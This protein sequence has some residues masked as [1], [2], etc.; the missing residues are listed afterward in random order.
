MSDH[1]SRNPGRVAVILRRNALPVALLMLLALV[2]V[3]LDGGLTLSYRYLID[4]A[5]VPANGRILAGVL[6][7]LGAGV[8]LSSVTS[9]ARDRA[10]ARRLTSILHDVRSAIFDHVQ[11]LS[12]ATM[13]KIRSA[14]VVARFSTDLAGLETALA[15]A[16][17]G[18][19]LP[20]LGVLVG[21]VLLFVV[22]RWPVAIAATLVWPLVLLGPRVVAP[23]AARASY[24]KKQRE[25]ALLVRV[26]EV[27]EAHRTIK[28]FGLQPFARER[29]GRELAD[30]SAAT[31]RATFLASLVERTTVITIYAMQVTAVAAGAVLAYRREVSVGAL[32][33]FLTIFWNLGW[34]IVVIGRGAPGIVAAWGSVQRID[35]LLREPP[36]AAEVLDLPALAPLGE[37]IRLDDATFAY[38]G[39]RAALLLAT[40][41]I[42]A[43]ESVAFVGPSG[44]GKSTV[45]SLIARFYDPS[46]GRVFFD[47]VD[48]RTVSPASLR[49]QMGFVMQE[50]FLFDATVRENIRIGR[51]DATDADVEEAARAA[52]IHDAI[53]AMPKGYDTPVGERGGNLSGGQRQRIAIARALVRRPRVLLLDEASSALDPVSEAAINATLSAAGRGRTT[54]SVTHRLAGATRAD[55]IF[56]VSDARIV[57]QGTH[58]ELLARGR[59]YAELWQKQSGFVLSGDGAQA[60]I[61]CDRLRAI[62]LFRPL[63][64]AQLDA[65]ARTLVTA[66]S[67]AGQR[68]VEEGHPGDLFYL[69]ARGKVRVTQRRDDGAEVELAR[70]GDGD[71]FGELALLRDAPRN[72]T[73]TCIT[74]SLLLSLTRGQFLELIATTP[75]VR[76]EIERVA[77]ERTAK[78]RGTSLAA[79]LQ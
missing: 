34:S 41:E 71:Q 55:R 39:K 37:S 72:A 38:D 36:D 51:L 12:L 28:A 54:I 48:A 24:A 57:E 40:L 52:E 19:I 64:D 63:D 4:E 15:G 74:D 47:D 73:V 22:L 16:V 1:P 79:T 5:I 61:S 42:R 30:V 9:I 68:V 66:H 26:D 21:V 62:A 18:L 35:E 58:E 67:A 77:K 13:S 45:L 29:F 27:V 7:A 46:S 65:L 69:I 75:R 8:V 10:Y 32:V 2:E 76:D 78:A 23:H 31:T 25:A 70:L 56:V 49:A 59:V 3:A 44:S 43:G 17:G 14:D 50:A 11:R 20:C 33:S 60:R 6:A 53:A